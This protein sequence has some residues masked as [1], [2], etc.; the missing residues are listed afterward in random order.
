[1]NVFADV[2]NN[3]TQGV[4]DT[5]GNIRRDLS[6][7]VEEEGYRYILGEL[8]NGTPLQGIKPDDI[9]DMTDEQAL[10]FIRSRSINSSEESSEYLLEKKLKNC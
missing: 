9:K 4:N 1:M 3:I 6:L 7:N 8:R 10:N 2:A 5:I